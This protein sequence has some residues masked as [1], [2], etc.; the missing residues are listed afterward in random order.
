MEGS[1]PGKLRDH[2]DSEVLGGEVTI[3]GEPANERARI[4]HQYRDV[5]RKGKVEGHP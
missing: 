4:T 5:Y 2:K 3:L 1:K